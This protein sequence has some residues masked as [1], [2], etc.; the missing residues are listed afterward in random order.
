MTIE[1]K[2]IERLLQISGWT[3]ECRML[4]LFEQYEMLLTKGYTDSE[5]LNKM[6]KF[7]KEKWKKESRK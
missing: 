7:Y 4:P 6:E 2:T 1:N 3:S 5:A